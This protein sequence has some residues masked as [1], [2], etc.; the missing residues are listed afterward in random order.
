MIKFTTEYL[1]RRFELNV[2]F[3]F[4][5]ILHMATSMDKEGDE[6]Q[7]ENASVVIVTCSDKYTHDR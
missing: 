5:V 7:N 1:Q 3:I 2:L 4:S 6:V